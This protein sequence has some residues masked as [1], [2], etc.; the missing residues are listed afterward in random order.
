L[1]RL[2]VAHRT[3]VA[4]ATAEGEDV[5]RAWFVGANPRLK[6]IPPYL[7]IRSGEFG[8]VVAAATAFVD[9]TDN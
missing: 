6:E 7:V 1:A 4:L 9:G 5:A 3:W 2:Q 8:K